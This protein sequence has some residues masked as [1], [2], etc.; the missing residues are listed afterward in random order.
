MKLIY[1]TKV[2]AFEIGVDIEAAF[3]S[4]LLIS[5]QLIFSIVFFFAFAILWPIPDNK[6]VHASSISLAV[7][8]NF[9]PI[10]E[11]SLAYV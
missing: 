4:R 10:I 8:N 11:L 9:S 2:I 3:K 6:R 1:N 5:F 7:K